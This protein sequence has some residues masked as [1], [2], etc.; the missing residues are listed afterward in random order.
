MRFIPSRVHAI[1][2]YGAGLLLIWLPDLLGFADGTAA[3]FI[4]QA[5]GAAVLLMSLCTDYEFSAVKLVP[6]PVHLGID[7]AAGLLLVVSPWLFG[8]ADRVM[9]P[10]VIMSFLEIGLGLTTR[11]VRDD[12]LATSTGAPT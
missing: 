10:H 12:H 7:V 2:D 4:M 9:W 8:F 11:A 5:V 3:Q 6:L 1:L